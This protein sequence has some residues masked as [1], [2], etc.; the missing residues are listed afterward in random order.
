MRLCIEKPEEKRFKAS[1]YILQEDEKND[2][3]KDIDIKIDEKEGSFATIKHK[4][5]I[6][7]NC[8]DS[9]SSEG[10]C[11]Y[12]IKLSPFMIECYFNEQLALT[13]NERQLLNYEK[14]RSKKIKDTADFHVY[15]TQRKQTSLGKTMDLPKGP[16]S[17]ALDF[18]F[19]NLFDL[20]GLPE[21]PRDCLIDNTDKEPYRMF[22]LDFFD[23]RIRNQSL[24]GNIPFIIGNNSEKPFN[25]AILWANASDTYLTASKKENSRDICF[26]SEAGVLECFTFLGNSVFDITASYG[27]LI[28]QTPMPQYFSLGY[29]QCRWDRDTQ[30]IMEESNKM[31][32]SAKIPCDCLWLDIEH[33]DEKKYF[34]WDHKA[35]P[36]PLEMIQNFHNKGRKLVVIVD[37]HLKVDPEYPIYSEAISQGII[38]LN[39]DKTVFEGNC[40]PG[41]SIWLDYLNPKA[42]QYWASLFCLEKYKETTEDTFIWNDMNEPAIFDI[43]ENTAPKDALY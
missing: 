24:Y 39:K 13:L 8:M 36:K 7:N 16:S 33:T 4:M 26:I 42:R 41:K 2:L 12:V 27:K 25:A 17:V 21:R 9:Y 3:A 35:F 11:K 5:K 19:H 28:G 1:K 30:E 38:I 6:A 23:D 43:F 40:W 20:Y 15:M 34:T 29:N 31:F 22:N 18:S 32:E 14:Y 10:E 37:P